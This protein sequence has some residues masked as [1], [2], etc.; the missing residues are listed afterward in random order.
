MIGHCMELV[1][2]IL[3]T[4]Q[5]SNVLDKATTAGGFLIDLNSIAAVRIAVNQPSWSKK[6]F[7]YSSFIPL[8]RLFMVKIST[9]EKSKL[10]KER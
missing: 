2:K 5:G 9:D 10:K 4:L 1:P 6:L 3:H 8:K 7:L